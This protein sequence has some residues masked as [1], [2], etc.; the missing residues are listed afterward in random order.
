[1]TSVLASKIGTYGVSST[2]LGSLYSYVSELVNNLTTI[3]NAAGNVEAHVTSADMGS[4]I[5]NATTILGQVQTNLDTMKS[6]LENV[7]D[8]LAKIDG[9]NT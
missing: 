7:L 8:L 4:H 3:T 1:M 9:Y 5:S 2:A 6:Q